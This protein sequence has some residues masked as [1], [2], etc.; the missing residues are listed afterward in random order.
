[1]EPILLKPSPYAI[2]LSSFGTLPGQKSAG[3]PCNEAAQLVAT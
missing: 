3:N 2:A 1:M